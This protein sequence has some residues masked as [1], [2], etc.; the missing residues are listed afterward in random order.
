MKPIVEKTVMYK[1]ENDNL[2]ISEECLH[3]MF[4]GLARRESDDPT[5]RLY[6]YE[7]DIAKRLPKK[8]SRKMKIVRKDEL[9]PADISNRKKN[10]KNVHQ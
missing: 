5:K 9:R 2:A 7:K 3:K 8:V 1:D 4:V 6:M 10:N